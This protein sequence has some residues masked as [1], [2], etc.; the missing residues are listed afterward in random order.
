M[1]PWAFPS[2]AMPTLTPAP[3]RPR[4]TN[5]AD[6]SLRALKDMS[7]RL[8]DRATRGEVL[9]LVLDFAAEHFRRVAMFMVREEDAVGIAQRGLPRAGGPGDEQ[10]LAL[11]VPLHES[12]WLRSVLDTG[13]SLRAGPSDEGDRRLAAKLGSG[14]P[15][16]AFVAPI[17][18]G[19]RVAALLYGD[20]L[21]ENGSIGDTTVL[22]IV[23]HEAGLALERAVLERALALVEGPSR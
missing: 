23:L 20:N 4:R 10:F 16:E 14:L 21:P 13:E 22:A 11:R 5:S 12:A 9:N 7:A 3:P 6:A 8:R 17:E 15:I 2:E 18:S 19:G 1:R